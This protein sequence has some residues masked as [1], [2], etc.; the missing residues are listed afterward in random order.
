MV[1][2][3]KT[4]TKL[5]DK[6]CRTFQNNNGIR[7]NAFKVNACQSKTSINHKQ[8]QPSPHTA[9][10]SPQP[11]GD[12]MLDLA[13]HGHMILNTD[14]SNLKVLSHK[15][16]CGV[17]CP[18]KHNRSLSAS[19]LSYWPL[20]HNHPCCH[21]QWSSHLHPW[22][23]HP[24]QLGPSL[25]LWFH[26]PLQH[27][28]APPAS[29]ITVHHRPAPAH[30]ILSKRLKCMDTISLEIL[31]LLLTTALKTVNTFYYYTIHYSYIT[32]AVTAPLDH[33][34]RCNMLGGTGSPNFPLHL[35]WWCRH[36]CPWGWV[37]LLKPT[38]MNCKHA[39][40]VFMLKLRESAAYLLFQHDGGTDI[41]A[42]LHFLF[43]E[44]TYYQDPFEVNP[45]TLLVGIAYK[46]CWWQL[47]RHSQWTINS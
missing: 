43:Y 10:T 16:V 38:Q 1:D 20:E 32:Q 18:C 34:T 39:S 5:F 28:T 8:P 6:Y 15:N 11:P 41:S 44:K 27:L 17:N 35:L 23:M 3:L 26:Y 37:A 22:L 21:Q 7:T 36:V 33:F 13:S 4:M 2:S 45:D 14:V 40:S 47:E 42:L 12:C 24:C 9:H 30:T 46:Q 29:D 31:S 25:H 19:K